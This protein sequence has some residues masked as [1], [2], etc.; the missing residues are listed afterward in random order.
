[1]RTFSDSAFESQLHSR[2]RPER[3]LDI[4]RKSY[5]T[6]RPLYHLDSQLFLHYSLH[7]CWRLRYRMYLLRLDM[8]MLS[9]EVPVFS[10]VYE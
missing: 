4:L 1:M 2:S 8:K 10:S 3:S 6:R 9:C 5:E 7:L